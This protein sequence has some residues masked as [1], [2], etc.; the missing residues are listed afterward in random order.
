M[1]PGEVVPR[2]LPFF[3]LASLL[4]APFGC[5]SASNQ[6]KPSEPKANEPAASSAETV[7]E[8]DP[9]SLM[10]VDPDWSPTSSVVVRPPAP[11]ALTEY[12]DEGYINIKDLWHLGFTHDTDDG[13]RVTQAALEQAAQHWQSLRDRFARP[14]PNA[15]SREFVY[16]GAERMS[17]GWLHVKLVEPG[18]LPRRALRYQPAKLAAAQV[19]ILHAQY[20]PLP[21]R[22]TGSWP[23][24]RFTY[25]ARGN[26]DA[27]GSVRLTAGAPLVLPTHDDLSSYKAVAEGFAG[28]R[29]SVTRVVGDRALP[30][31]TALTYAGLRGELKWMQELSPD[32]ML[33]VEGLF[34]PLP[35]EPVGV[36]A[37]WEVT[38]VDDAGGFVHDIYDLAGL[39]GQ[40]IEVL[41]RS[42]WSRLL[43]DT[44]GAQLDR[45]EGNADGTVALWLDRI[46][47]ELFLDVWESVYFNDDRWVHQAS[48]STVDLSLEPWRT[49]TWTIRARQ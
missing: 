42:Y 23:S 5:H 48:V 11:G 25:E 6:P 38:R 33:S 7:P 39:H 30:C 10:S 15:V 8:P 40:R 18:E 43:K 28:L 45:V 34:V 27:P 44:G 22:A 41:R 35:A 13:E 3:P 1:Y 19:P 20:A 26:A 32:V 2:V 9:S 47:P 46:E 49:N 24:V 16:W 36:G 37:R 29:V 21:D 4:L 17:P 12:L 14:H 31:G